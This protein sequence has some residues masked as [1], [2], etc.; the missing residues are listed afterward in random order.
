MPAG[1]ESADLKS[2]EEAK[3]ELTR[4]NPVSASPNGS[5]ADQKP[6]KDVGDAP[7]VFVKGKGQLGEYGIGAGVSGDL[8]D[9]AMSNP[10]SALHVGAVAKGSFDIANLGSRPRRVVSTRVLRSTLF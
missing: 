8:S 3:H 1:L 10:V 7:G 5:M 2:T 4:R 9:Q 6:L